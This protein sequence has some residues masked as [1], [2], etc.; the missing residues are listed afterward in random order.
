[1]A[2]SL[3]ARSLAAPHKEGGSAEST[4]GA[5]QRERGR[6]RPVGNLSRG[7]VV[8]WSHLLKWRDHSG[9][10]LGEHGVAECWRPAAM[11]FLIEQEADGTLF[12]FL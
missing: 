10:D 6:L 9:A 1:M 4:P 5:C 7:S 3:E 8:K 11:G 2:V 12:F